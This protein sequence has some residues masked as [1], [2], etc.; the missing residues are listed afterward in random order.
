MFVLCYDL[1]RQEN[2][3]KAGAWLSIALAILL[4]LQ[5][6]ITFEFK[7]HVLVVH[8]VVYF[9]LAFVFAQIAAKFDLNQQQIR[10]AYGR[11]VYFDIISLLLVNLLKFAYMYFSFY[12]SEARYFSAVDLICLVL[13]YHHYRKHRDRLLIDSYKVES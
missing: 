11:V 12:R 8:Y 2:K 10:Q 9:V 4:V 13:I 3:R 5:L 7:R 6:L 1:D